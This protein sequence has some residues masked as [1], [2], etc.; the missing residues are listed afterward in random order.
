[1]AIVP[2]GRRRAHLPPHLEALE[3]QDINVRNTTPAIDADAFP[4][5]TL[6][7]AEMD[8]LFVAEMEDRK[9]VV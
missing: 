4:D 8:A 7:E 9:S 5:D 3:L 1:M 2:D 6:T